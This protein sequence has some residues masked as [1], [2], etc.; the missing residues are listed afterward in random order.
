MYESEKYAL[1]QNY[2]PNYTLNSDNIRKTYSM[3]DLCH[4]YKYE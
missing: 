1:N 4:G 2:T 3:D